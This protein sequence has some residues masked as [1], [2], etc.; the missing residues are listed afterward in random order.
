M[1]DLV[2]ALE[3]RLALERAARWAAE[4]E[5]ERCRQDAA[6]MSARQEAL[7]SDRT[8]EIAR[9]RDEAIASSGAKSAFVANVSHEIRTPLTSII[10]FAELLLDDR[11][12]PIDRNEA[13]QT[14]IRNGRHL[15]SMVNDILDLSKIETGQVRAER[16]DFP[17]PV[18]LRE[19]T[20]LVAGKVEE[21]HL[22]F[23]VEPVLPLP[24]AVRTDPVRLKQILLN[25]IANAVKFTR[26]G[27]VTLGLA[28]NAPSRVLRLTV[29]DTGIGM[30]P[31]QLAGLFQ[32][33]TQ[34]DISTTR[35]FGGT[36]LGLYISKQLCDLLGARI[37]VDSEPGRGSA[38]HVD[39]DQTDIESAA[40]LLT[41]EG[42]LIDFDRQ[43]FVVTQVSVPELQGCVLVVDD[44]EDIRRLVHAY[45]QQ[46]GLTVE[47]AV[48][49][50][51][52]IAM[53][54]QRKYDLVLMDMQMPGIDGV[55]ATR[56]L[57]ARGVAT[58]IVA[59]TAN[60]MKSD[61]RRYR[62][63][64]CTDVLAKPIDREAFYDV[65]ERLLGHSLAGAALM[66]QPDLQATLDAL[67]DEFLAGLPSHLER[68]A[69]ALGD[70][71]WPAAQSVAH[72]IKGT[73]GSF[74]FPALTDVAGLAELA[75]RAEEFGRAA[76]ICGRLLDS[77]SR[78]LQSA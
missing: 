36:G 68:L 43:P 32:P 4:L 22:E 16:I 49:G 41:F 28:W 46:A 72:T 60:V 71:D 26:T 76:A 56:A 6:R 57:R 13:V 30:T 77:G 42:D 9:A 37:T 21:R 50:G 34:A 14:I 18:L 51:E 29:T 31:E 1:K 78:A 65:V 40:E 64:G 52:A 39:I 66:V 3:R 7:L 35:K 12:A 11:A 45:L 70:G 53:G 48:D 55:S 20:E 8:A 17:L 10:G 23:R 73:A 15:L 5:L 67:R 24:A 38:F 54:T 62:A 69:K 33:F 59:L 27:S 74:G 75:I 44:G 2:Q 61:V 63:A 19:L 47:T 25:L 58:P